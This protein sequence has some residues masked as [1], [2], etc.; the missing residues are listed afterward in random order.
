MG[1]GAM[2]GLMNCEP[3][4]GLAGSLVQRVIFCI[5]GLIGYL[6]YLRMKPSLVP[7]A[8]KSPEETASYTS[9]VSETS[10]VYQE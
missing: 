1:F 5:L 2:Y 6:I 3:S 8:V 10:E 4:L 7:A 9:E